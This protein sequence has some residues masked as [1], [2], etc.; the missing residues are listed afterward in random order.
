MACHTFLYL[1]AL[2][3]SVTPPTFSHFVSLSNIF[4]LFFLCC[5]FS[6][7]TQVVTRCSSLSFLV[8][9]PKTVA[10]RLRILF[11]S[12]LVSASCN[13]IWFDFSAVHEIHSILCR[14][15]ISVVSSFFCNCFKIVQASHP[16][17]KMGSI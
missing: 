15:H 16:Y 9:W 14:N 8:A 11:K 6:S 4:L 7:I 12:D 10:W 2:S 17:I 1:V 13:T 3:A 5:G